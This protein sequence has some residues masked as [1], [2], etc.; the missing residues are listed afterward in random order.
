MEKLGA[1]I[2]GSKVYT[3]IR[4]SDGAPM[5]FTADE[6]RAKTLVHVLGKGFGVK[7]ESKK[8]SREVLPEEEE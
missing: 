2:K 1:K 8:L 5:A 4:K 3:V 7:E 6:E